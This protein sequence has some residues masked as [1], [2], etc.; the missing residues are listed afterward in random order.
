MKLRSSR[1]SRPYQ[2]GISCMGIVGHFVTSLAPPTSS[3][4][5]ATYWFTQSFLCLKN[6]IRRLP[7]SNIRC[8]QYFRCLRIRVPLWDHFRTS[9]FQALSLVESQGS[10]PPVS[11]RINISSTWTSHFK[12]SNFTQPASKLV[13]IKNNKNTHTHTLVAPH[14]L[15][16]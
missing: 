8:F 9:K 14:R 4:N 15:L 10:N 5:K 16:L 6:L 7:L 2:A 3:N 13:S 12:T 11:I 1:N